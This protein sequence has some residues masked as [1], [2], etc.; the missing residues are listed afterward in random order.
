MSNVVNEQV[1]N[2]KELTY[3]ICCALIFSISLI[4]RIGLVT[5]MIEFITLYSDFLSAPSTISR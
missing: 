5:K 4:A 3:S 2:Y 1:I